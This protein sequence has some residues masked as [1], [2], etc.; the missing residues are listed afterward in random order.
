MLGSFTLGL[1]PVVAALAIAGNTHVIE[2]GRQPRECRVAALAIRTGDDM[3][4]RF[5]RGG[6]AVVAGKTRLRDISVVKQGG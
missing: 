5:A 6:G 3:P 1:H 4:G 2:P